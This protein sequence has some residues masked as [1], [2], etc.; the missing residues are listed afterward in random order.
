MERS[1]AENRAVLFAGFREGLDLA[2]PVFI[3]R[4]AVQSRWRRWG[5]LPVDPNPMPRLRL[6]S[7]SRRRA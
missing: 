7:R 5:W 1:E 4:H 6:F 3:G 2:P